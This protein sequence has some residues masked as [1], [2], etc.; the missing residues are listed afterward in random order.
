M[1]G[2]D[3]LL[4]ETLDRLRNLETDESEG[5]ELGERV[6]LDEQE[7]FRGRWRGVGKM[8]TK[9]G[10]KD[11][12]LLWGPADEPRFH[13]MTTRLVWEIDALDPPVQV[14]DEIAIVR[15]TDI[16]SSNP[17]YSPTQRF[18]V[19]VRPCGDPLPDE[20]AGGDDIPF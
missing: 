19:R 6:V 2:D 5:D 3:E 9:D 7:T 13:Y 4:A 15:G 1:S 8:H 17:E 12:Y 14:G 20:P 10:T 11:V 16:P 18:A